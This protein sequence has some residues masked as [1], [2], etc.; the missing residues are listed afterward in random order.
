[1][2]W[3]ALALALWGVPSRA[4]EAELQS[5]LLSRQC[6]ALETLV[7]ESLTRDPLDEAAPWYW[8]RQAANDPRGRAELM[9]RARACV[10]DRP[11]SA[12]CQH[13]LGVLIGAEL[14][15]DGGLAAMRGIGKVRERFE[16]AVELA[17]H[18]YAMRRDLLGFQLDVPA[19]MGGSAR[20]AREQAQALERIDAPR[21]VLLQTLMAIS[22]KAFDMAEQRLAGVQ[23]GADLQLA[24]DLRAVQ[25]DFGLA[26]LDSETA[27][28][29]RAWFERLAQ[30]DPSDPDVQVGRGRALPVLKQPDAAASAFERALQLNPRLRIAHRLGA[31]YEAAGQSAK[32]I[33]A[34]RRALTGPADRAAADKTRDWL[35]ALQR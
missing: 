2:R 32:A 26:M 27:G 12:R 28:R 22:D 18:D 9:P 34:Y 35:K 10:R 33:D 13:L 30:R 23:P 7:R 29:A 25:I 20:K 14:T 16:C 11:Q 8:G 24:S 6:G 21:G 17:P 1:M 19:L 3:S 15:D 5:L 31:A 4:A